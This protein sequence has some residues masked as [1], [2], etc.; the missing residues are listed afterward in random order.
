MIEFRNVSYS[1][2]NDAAENLRNINL[3]IGPGEFIVITGKSG[4]GKT[5]LSKCING[6]IPYFHE[7]ELTGDALIG[8]VNTKQMALHEIGAKVGS[9]FQDPRAQFFTTN[10][11]DEVAFRCQNMGLAREE[12]W[13]RVDE[14]FATLNIEDLRD[15]SI[16]HIS[17]GEKQKIAIDRFRCL[18]PGHA[19]LYLSAG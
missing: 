3:Q 7:G 5:T 8:G 11:T 16:F 15:Q 9:V 10:T 14:A 12:V 1:Y 6:L 2:P 19:A 17:S 18:L 4:C 13:A